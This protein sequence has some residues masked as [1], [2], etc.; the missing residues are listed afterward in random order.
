MCS[1]AFIYSIILLFTMPGFSLAARIDSIVI[2]DGNTYTKNLRLAVSII[3]EA[4]EICFSCNSENWTNWQAYSQNTNFLL[5]NSYGCSTVDGNKTIY[6][7]ARDSSGESLA[8]ASIILDRKAPIAPSNIAVALLDKKVKVSWAAASD[9]SG[10]SHYVLT[11]QEYGLQKKEFTVTVPSDETNY[12]HNALERRKYCYLVTA[13]DLA[14]NS[15]T[16]TKEQCVVTSTKGPEFT[17]SVFDANMS[18]RDFNGVSYFSA[19]RINIIVE[20]LDINVIVK[21]IFGSITQGNETE[22]LSFIKNAN[23]FLSDYNLKSI[24]GEAKITVTLIDNLDL[25]STQTLSLYVDSTPPDINIVS[26]TQTGKNELTAKVQHSED[27]FKIV[28]SF[29][30]QEQIFDKGFSDSSKEST[31]K[32]DLNNINSEKITLNFVALDFVMNKAEAKAEKILL[33]NAEAKANDLEKLAEQISEKISNNKDVA[34][35]EQKGIAEELSGL[36]S[37][38]TDLKEKMSSGDYETSRGVLTE[39]KNNLEQLSSK[40]ADVSLAQS[41]LI[42]YHEEKLVFYDELKGYFKEF[43]TN[44]EKLWKNL[45]IKRAINLIEISSSSGKNYAIVVSLSIKNVSAETLSNF[46]MVDFVPEKIA[47]DLN[48][49][50]SNYPSQFGKNPQTIL[51]EITALEPNESIEL[52][53]RGK[54]LLPDEFNG[55]KIENSDFHV[56]VPLE[57]LRTEITFVK[58]S[59]SFDIFPLLFLI[60]AS[61][62]AFI[63]IRRLKK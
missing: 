7:K 36:K 22:E 54:L 9:S 38:I 8:M 2:E 27:V 51:F 46:Y 11:I 60:L 32:I 49:V 39:L 19:E 61:F 37:K 56:P 14:G 1:K 58:K 40:I 63:L 28:V 6:V 52:K 20:L 24:D 21:D 45:A 10:I 41:Y 25:N 26:L 31:L 55:L 3:A 23:G 34:L 50:K 44:T 42:D 33:L 29:G 13:Y 53:Y 15:S 17:L 30:S 59:K 57:D 43:P 4:D 47:R 62:F 35:F 16:S 12:E 48:E 18:Q 5:T